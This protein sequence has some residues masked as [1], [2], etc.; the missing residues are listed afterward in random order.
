[1]T[2]AAPAATPGAEPAPST[3]VV[4][5]APAERKTRTITVAAD[6]IGL[7]V[8]VDGQ[9][10]GVTPLKNLT[11]SH[12]FHNVQVDTAAYNADINANTAG[13]LRY[14]SALKRWEWIQ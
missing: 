6:V 1:G 11:L 8:L 2:A 3:A 7:P 12:G 13:T 4:A 14:S 9:R 5:T 10:K